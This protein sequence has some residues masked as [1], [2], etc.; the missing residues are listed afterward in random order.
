MNI[1]MSMTEKNLM[2]ALLGE[3]LARNKYTYFSKIAKKEGFEQI[4]AIFLE[5]AGNE[6]EHA[7]LFYNFLDNEKVEIVGAYNA[8]MGNT[9]YN[10]ELAYS[11]ENEENTILYPSFAQIAKEEGF[12]QVYDCFSHVVEVEKHHEKRYR[13]LY[14]DVLE[15]KV[16]KFDK[17]IN[18]KCRNCGYI[19]HTNEVNQICPCCKHP[20][21]YFEILCDNYNEE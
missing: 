14:K 16:F 15:D 2:K 11:G 20:R 1:K 19:L 9:L 5:T 17:E 18:W 10:L 13:A 21:A 6:H 12:I 3:S 7:K 4:A 8:G